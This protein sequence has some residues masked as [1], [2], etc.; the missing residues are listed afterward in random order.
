VFA[1]LDGLVQPRPA[2]RM[3]RTPGAAGTP[4]PLVG[5]HTEAVLAEFAFSETAVARFTEAGAVCQAQPERNQ[6][7]QL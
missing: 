4:A 3:S 1:D 7:T 5:E 2:P 6:G